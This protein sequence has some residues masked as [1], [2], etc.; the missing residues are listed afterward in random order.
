MAKPSPARAACS[1]GKCGACTALI[2]AALRT[3]ARPPVQRRGIGAAVRAN[4]S[5]S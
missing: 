4:G 3:E 2:L 1:C 5:S